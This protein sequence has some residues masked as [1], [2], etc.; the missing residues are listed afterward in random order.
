MPTNRN[1]N[2]S[3][4]KEAEKIYLHELPYAEMVKSGTT[5]LAPGKAGCE[6]VNSVRTE[7]LF[8]DAIA[9]KIHS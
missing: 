9:I 4:L 8:L 3:S 7:I 6:R 1:K 2:Q 5:G